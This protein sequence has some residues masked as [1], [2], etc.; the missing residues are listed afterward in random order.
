MTELEPRF[1][2]PEQWTWGTFERNNRSIRFGYASTKDPKATIVCL[3]GLSEFSEKYF[4]TAH[5]ALKNGYNFYTMD[6]MGQG[7]SGRYLS[8]KNKRHSNGYINDVLDL[9]HF[10]D[11]HVP[12]T[13]PLIML[14]H[15]TGANIG[16]RYLD[17]YPGTFKIAAFTAPL[18]GI[19]ELKNMPS[20]LACGMAIIM[21]SLMWTAYV[22][23]GKNWHQDLREGE[24]GHMFS[25]DATR[26]AIHNYWCM[27]DPALQ[28]GSPTYR[29]LHDAIRS[30]AYLEKTSSIKTP[31]LFALAGDDKIVDNAAARRTI[32]RI[33]NAKTLELPGA[34]HEILMES[35]K[36]RDKFLSAFKDFIE[37][38]EPE[39]KKQHSKAQE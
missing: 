5:W 7:K 8:D 1:Q 34:Q 6:W 37:T 18:L 29:W 20:V 30:C 26:A 19:A 25:S 14:G 12:H 21:N 36:Y 22:P 23:G 2:Q 33:E 31:T 24:N 4:E 27:K 9:A 35:D 11:N 13:H 16:L 38:L 3:H 10:I 17:M 15:S 28:V 32:T 39:T